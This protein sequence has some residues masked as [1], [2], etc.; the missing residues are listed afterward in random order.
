MSSKARSVLQRWLRVEVEPD[1]LDAIVIGTVRRQEGK[2]D[3][4][5]ERLEDAR[6]RLT[7]VDAV[8]V[9]HEMNASRA[10]IATGEMKSSWPKSLL[11]F[12]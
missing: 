8:V 1:A 6:G 9:E 2:D 4:V 12:E 5:S 10:A 3:A 7:L 11:D